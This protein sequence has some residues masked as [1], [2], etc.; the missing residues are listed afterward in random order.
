MYL[1]AS[2]PVLRLDHP[3]TNSSL[4]FTEESLSQVKTGYLVK[5]R[6]VKKAIR[7]TK[8][9]IFR[10]IEIIGARE[11]AW[12]FLKCERQT[13][14]DRRNWGIFTTKA[15]RAPRVLISLKSSELL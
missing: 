15:Q 3:Q 12:G 2:A 7:A 13:S 10:P 11:K 4:T 1:Q 14:N 6:G 9:T 8:E 5:Q